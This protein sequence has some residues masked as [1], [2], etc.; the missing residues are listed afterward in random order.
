M[1]KVV[2]FGTSVGAMVAHLN[3]SHDPAWEVA[4]FTVDRAFLKEDRFRGLP[5]VP[6]E[7]VES[8]Y[9]PSEFRMLVA[10]QAHRM[11][12]LRAE[13]C[14]QAREK[15]YRLISYVHPSALVA[16]EVKMGDN[17]FISEGAIL[18]PFLTLGEDVIVMPGATLGHHA[19]IKDHCFIGN[20]A[21]VMSL[22]TMEPYCFVGPNATVLEAVT[23]GAEA[24]IGGGV[25]IQGDVKEK[26]VYK[27][28][29]PVKLALPSDR[30]AKIIFR[31]S[32]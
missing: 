21:V 1:E 10:V 28:A 19:V 6:F 3:L 18:R 8:L 31:K 26:E 11:N 25:V 30:L 22:V 24:L 14:A 9:P 2:L 20:R 4:A 12:K 27:A 15:G 5:V 29:A 16:P 23:V 7:E 32:L 17:C 13:K